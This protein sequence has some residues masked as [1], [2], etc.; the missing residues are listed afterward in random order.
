MLALAAV[1]GLVAG[2]LRVAAAGPGVVAGVAEDEAAFVSLINQSRAANGQPAMSADAAAADVARAW[3]QRMA[4]AGGLSHNP[5]LANDVSVHVTTQ[6][7]RIGENVGVGYSVRGLHDAFM[8]S[9]GHRANILG[10]FNRVGVGVVKE[11]SGRIWVTVVFV[12]GPSLQQSDPRGQLDSVTRV[13][14]G[15]RVTGWALDPDTSGAIEVH[16]YVDSGGTNLGLAQQPRPDVSAVYPGHGPGLGYDAVISAPSGWHNVCAYGINVGAGVNRLLA[17]RW[18]LVE[19][20]PFGSFDGVVQEPGGLRVSG[21]AIDPDVADPV[22]VHVYVDGGG[23]NLGPADD[24]RPDVAAYYPAYGPSRGFDAVISAPPGWRQVCAYAIN[25]RAGAHGLLGCKSVLVAADPFGSLD[26]IARVPGGLQVSGWAIDPESADPIDVHVYVDSGGTN[27]GTAAGDRPDVGAVMGPYG[28]P[29]GFDS[30]VPAAP[31]WRR[32]CAYGINVR[33]GAN[34]AIACRTLFV[35]ADPF[36]SFDA[37]AP[38]EGGVRV[39]GWAIDP[40]TS[41]PIEVHVYVG[42]GGTN[43]GEAKV[44]RPD[45][46]AVVGGYGADHGFD[47]VVPASP[48]VHEVCAYGINVGAGF[49]RQ[50]G[51]KSVRVG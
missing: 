45:V 34:R 50:L 25:L 6:W 32:V 24:P 5:N 14:G 38:V 17:C 21:W 36:G 18:V 30:A 9:A 46:G 33:A 19:A 7:T 16:V 49:H 40:E 10:D 26:G 8:S 15:L 35:T 12:K 27:I 44:Q 11:A 41:M 23:T 28:S 51:C 47:T 20:N 1:L 42:G 3:S 43:L 13:P 31:G 22:E 4:A 37:A 29:H 39:T 2:D 48:G